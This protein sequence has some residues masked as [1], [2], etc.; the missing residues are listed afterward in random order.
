[1]IKRFNRIFVFFLFLFLTLPSFVKADNIDSMTIE[2]N[3]FLRGK[4]VQLGINPN[5]TLGTFPISQ[6]TIDSLSDEDKAKLDE[7]ALTR[8]D[9][10][11]SLGMRF[12]RYGWDSDKAPTSGDFTVSNTKAQNVNGSKDSIIFSIERKGYQPF[13]LRSDYLSDGVSIKSV[14]DKSD[15]SNGILKA[16]VKGTV[17]KGSVDNPY[18]HF[19]FEIEYY[20]R[21]EST[22]YHTIIK[23]D[24][25]ANVNDLYLIKLFNP[26]QDKLFNRTSMTYNKV[27]SIPKKYVESDNGY[28]MVVARGET[29]LDGMFY[30]SFDVNSLPGNNISNWYV[31]NNNTE[32]KADVVGEN[33]IPN[34]FPLVIKNHPNKATPESL[35][36]FY[37]GGGVN[38]YR[39]GDNTISISTKLKTGEV[40]ANTSYKT[41]IITSLDNDVIQGLGSL[42]DELNT[43]IIDRTDTT[44]KIKAKDDFSYSIV[45]CE[46]DE[47]GQPL[48]ESCALGSNP[49]YVTG[50]HNELLFDNLKP[51]TG[52]KVFYK[53]SAETET[54]SINT[55]TKKSAKA[56]TKLNAVVIT[57]NSITVKG[58]HGYE[59]SI[60]NG[61]HWS[62]L[63]TFSGLKPN[64]EYNF[65]GRSEA[66]YDDM[67]GQVSDVLTVK[68][69]PKESNALDSLPSN[70]DI[71]VK[72]VDAIP[73]LKINK[74][75]L[76]EAIKNDSDI[77]KFIQAADPHHKM[78]VVI[79]VIKLYPT[80]EEIADLNPYLKSRKIAYAFDIELKLYEDNNHIKDITELSS[81]I[82]FNVAIPKELQDEK[83][84]NIIR[85]HIISIHQPALYQVL[86]DIDSSNE[87]IT[88]ENGL[89][90]EFYVTYDVF[91]EK[92]PNTGDNIIAYIILFII[93]LGTLCY[94]LYYQN[95][96][97]K[98]K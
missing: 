82:S 74:A 29:T 81:D 28:S 75:L 13:T 18:I 79:D 53:N 87:T 19:D 6:A 90:S 12:N 66:T 92:N 69:L 43:E 42:M 59:Y 2:G 61:A 15:L 68:T 49:L 37:Q 32:S 26:D 71:D 96:Y 46:M 78:T 3:V 1:M 35:A 93:S 44:I 11:Y 84:F 8:L 50:N 60:D 57:E 34:F 89:F 55:R 64:T 14:E 98:N 91:D 80:D 76:Y 54:G 77:K 39:L 88:V 58:D 41:E 97:Y 16:I 45:E 85:K 70:F 38:G 5:G 25:K 21:A 95:K 27:I 33:L 20:F 24:N 31:C 51:A 63:E 86:E 52:Y 36:I 22:H 83:N 72:I 73:T 23:V 56:A 10:G 17:K 48:Y 4:Y 94:K 62:K 30:L 67:P 7:F 9:D 65:I 40:L 47:D